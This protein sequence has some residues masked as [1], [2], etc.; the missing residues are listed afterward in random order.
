M[1]GNTI[2]YECEILLCNQRL[3][4][5]RDWSLVNSPPGDVHEANAHSIVQCRDQTTFPDAGGTTTHF[6]VI[7]M[8][9]HFDAI[10]TKCD[11]EDLPKISS[12]GNH[13]FWNTRG[14]LSEEKNLLL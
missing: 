5:E 6:S 10:P 3:P 4:G 7:K 2:L 9:K 1:L 13:L 11:S 12:R 8:Q 14:Q